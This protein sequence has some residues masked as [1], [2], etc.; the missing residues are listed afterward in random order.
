MQRHVA[1]SITMLQLRLS[2]DPRKNPRPLSLLQL[3]KTTIGQVID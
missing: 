1:D 3:V 2:V